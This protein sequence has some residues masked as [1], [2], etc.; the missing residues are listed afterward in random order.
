MTPKVLS[1]AAAAL[2]AAAVVSALPAGTELYLASVGRGQGACVASVCSQWRTS[3]W[4]NNVSSATA[5]VE[6]AFLKRG[7]SNLSPAT[8]TV[9]VPA[10]QCV[11]F[12]DVLKV[13]LGLDGVFG[14]LRIRSDQPVFVTGRTFDSNVHTSKGVGGAGQDLPGTPFERAIANGGSTELSG[15]AQDA[16]GTTRSNFGF[17]EVTGQSCTVKADLLAADGTVLATK[18]Y[19]T[20]PFEAQQPNVTDIGGPSGTNLRVRLGVTAGPGAIVATSSRIDNTTGDPSTMDMSNPPVM[21]PPQWAGT[22]SGPY[23]NFYYGYQGTATIQITADVPARTW[24][25]TL[26][27]TGTFTGFGGNNP[28]PPQTLSGTIEPR[29]L[30]VKSSSSLFSGATGELR[31]DGVISTQAGLYYNGSV[32]G[33]IALFGHADGTTM[34]LAYFILYTPQVGGGGESVHA[35]LTKS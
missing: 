26:T 9:A 15:L 2:L 11:E 30:V 28:P 3:A 24:Q 5:N 35:T 8:A 14:A 12:L 34:D 7:Q 29:G 27:L 17:V 33:N 31:P 21:S 6:L 32:V 18:S 16:A 22:W 13:P 25:A 20:L 23:L 19:P 4:I 1:F 10:G